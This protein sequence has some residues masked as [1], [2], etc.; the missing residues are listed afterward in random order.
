[1][2]SIVISSGHGAKVSGAVDLLN[3]VTEARRVVAA[4]ATDLRSRGA[5]VT[6]FHENNATNQSQNLNN[7]VAFHNSRSRDLDVSIHFNHAGGGTVDRPIGT[8]VLFSTQQALAAKVSRAISL[9]SGLIDR[10]AKKR[11]DLSF[12]SRTAKPAILVEVCFVNSRADVAL[13]Q[14]NFNHICSAIG[15]SILGE[16]APTVPRPPQP[17]S[18]VPGGANMKH[19]LTIGNVE[20]TSGYD[21]GYVRFI[22]DLD[23]CNDGTGPS[24][25]DP[26]WQGQTAYRPYL[27]A[28]VDKYIVTP[29]QVRT[30]VKPVVIGCLGRVTHLPSR[31]WSWGVVG[32][33]GPST[34]TGECAYVLAKVLNPSISYNAGDSKQDYFYEFWPGIPAVVD[35]KQYQLVP[36]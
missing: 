17:E 2:K 21:G 29:P 7:I 30:G 8:E 31:R 6:E 18:S 3:E 9:S 20:I 25:G 34:K 36:A 35:G 12:L 4:V 26:S 16:S 22:S 14:P 33:V 32:D 15:A 27:N 19:F 28:D 11:D 1:M 13:Y 10:G 5:T 23:I 24:H